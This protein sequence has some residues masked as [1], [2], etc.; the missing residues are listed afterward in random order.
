MT[1][2]RGGNH[3]GVLR[4]P[5]REAAGKG[6]GVESFVA[7]VLRRTGAGGFVWSGTEGDHRA[8]AGLVS[9]PFR[10]SVGWD[11]DAAGDAGL[12]GAGGRA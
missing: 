12:A 11:A 9:G 7:Q 10:D 5:R 1:P 2:S 6:V 8:L 4:P 3:S